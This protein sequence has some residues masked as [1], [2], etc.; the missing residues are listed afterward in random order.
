M[1]T[2]L[3]GKNGKF[4]DVTEK[5]FSE[6]ISIIPASDMDR[7]N[8]FKIDPCGGVEKEIRLL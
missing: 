6:L 1:L 8:I 4:A 5:I 2:I 3:Y 7:Y